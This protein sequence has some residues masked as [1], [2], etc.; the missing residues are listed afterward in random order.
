M[1]VHKGSYCRVVRE[2]KGFV[3]LC[4]GDAR[5]ATRLVS[6]RDLTWTPSIRRT[7]GRLCVRRLVDVVTRIITSIFKRS[8]LRVGDRVR[9]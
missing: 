4:A 5:I 2:A 1:R 6:L 8:F 9:A 7:M 3:R